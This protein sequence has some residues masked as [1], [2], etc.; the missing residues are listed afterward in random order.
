MSEIKFR[1]LDYS[2]N[3]IYGLPHLRYGE[4]CFYIT[5][6]DG[7]RPSYGDPDSGETTIFTEVRHDTI[8][9]YTGLKDK[10]G[11]EIYEGDIIRYVDKGDIT[12]Y[13]KAVVWEDGMFILNED[14][15]CDLYLC[16]VCSD[17]NH[18]GSHVGFV[19][20]NIYEN[21]ELLEE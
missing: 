16:G 11:V 7:W 6:S 4:G 12:T 20:G 21:P 5:H 14:K 2:G 15:Y 10:D 9:Q 18:E 17:E 3:W 1:A 19:I 8:T 13:V